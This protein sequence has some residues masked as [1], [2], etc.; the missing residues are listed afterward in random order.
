VFPARYYSRLNALAP[1]AWM[2]R[3]SNTVIGISHHR[4]ATGVF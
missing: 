3:I 2:P 1:V 4:T